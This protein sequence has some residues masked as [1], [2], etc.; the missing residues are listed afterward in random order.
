MFVEET[1]FSRSF[2]KQ[3]LTFTDPLLI[4][5]VAGYGEVKRGNMMIF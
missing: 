3:C 5:G 1:I 2:H 4:V